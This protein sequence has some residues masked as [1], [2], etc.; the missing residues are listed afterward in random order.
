MAEE[1]GAILEFDTCLNQ[2]AAH[3]PPFPMRD[4]HGIA[5]AEGHLFATCSYDNAVAILSLRSGTWEKWYPAIEPEDRD[6]DVHHFNTIYV[7]ADQLLLLAHYHGPSRVYRYDLPTLDLLSVHHIGDHSHDLWRENGNLASCNSF[8]GYLESTTGPIL[9]TGYLPRGIVNGERT[10][11]V[12]LS[13]LAERGRRASCDARLRVFDDDVHVRDL[14]FPSEGMMLCLLSIPEEVCSAAM[15]AGPVYEA[16]CIR[17]DQSAAWRMEMN[18]ERA[19]AFLVSGEWHCAE[20]YRWSAAREASMQLP[21]NV[22]DRQLQL[23]LINGLPAQFHLT[24][25]A[26]DVP[27]S[28]IE[29]TETEAKTVTLDLPDRPNARYVRLTLVVPF[30]WSPA[31]LSTETPDARRLGIGVRSIKIF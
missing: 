20:E 28:R 19:D 29:F 3:E 26:D 22:E 2:V 18:S 1:R 4:L 30:L 21:I 17:Y 14:L 5:I 24:V 15:Q 9:R 12:G 23:D 16:T 27:L 25:F 13:E 6:K 7:E 11:V 31:N 8:K 10:R